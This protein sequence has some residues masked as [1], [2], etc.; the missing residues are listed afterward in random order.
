MQRGLYGRTT[1]TNFDMFRSPFAVISQVMA[2]FDKKHVSRILRDGLVRYRAEPRKHLAAFALFCLFFVVFVTAALGT[3][4]DLQSNLKLISGPFSREIKVDG[5]PRSFNEKPAL[6][7]AFEKAFFAMRGNDKAVEGGIED[8]RLLLSKIVPNVTEPDT[9]AS[10]LVRVNQL[11]VT[12]IAVN[13]AYRD[14]AMN[15]ICNLKRLGMSNY[16]VLAMDRAVYRYISQRKGNVFYHSRVISEPANQ[17]DASHDPDRDIPPGL[18]GHDS[19]QGD[20]DDE[21]HVF[22]SAGFVLTSRRK[23]MMVAEVV[24]L[25]Y[26]V[27]FC[28]ADVVLF[29]NPHS[30][31]AEFADDFVIM[32]DRRHEEQN[33]ALNRNIN[34]GFYFVRGKGRNFITLRA[35]VKYGLKVKRS[36]Q[37]AFNHVLCGGFKD[38]IAGP[39]WRYG[40][41]RCF[42]RAVGGVSAHVLT[43]DEFM[44]GSDERLFLFSPEQIARLHPSI[45]ALHVNYV[46]GRNA[47]IDRIKGIGQWFYDADAGQGLDGCLSQPK[48]DMLNQDIED[49]RSAKALPEAA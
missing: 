13:Y 42:Y 47:K 20:D 33:A 6:Q 37:K 40:D 11:N 10:L 38:D 12:V 43:A 15:L 36:E 18:D 26:D 35:I 27:L 3:R 7:L 17:Q 14:L 8:L 44:N 2:Y 31:L 29:K 48:A 34:S 32:S 30:R 16:L 5:R 28:D 24:M 25:G 21:G 4:R 41:N 9:E 1:V 22:G 23:S 19:E 49:P 46:R 45:I 39:G